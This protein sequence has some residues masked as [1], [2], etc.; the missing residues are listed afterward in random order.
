MYYDSALL[1]KCDVGNKGGEVI[2]I[3]SF[4]NGHRLCQLSCDGHCEIQFGI[5]LLVHERCHLNGY[6]DNVAF[7]WLVLFQL[8]GDFVVDFSDLRIRLIALTLLWLEQMR[9]ENDPIH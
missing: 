4:L 7:V 3:E 8:Q 6:G 9:V 2:S 1:S 5:A